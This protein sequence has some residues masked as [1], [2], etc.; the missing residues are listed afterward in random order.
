MG[1]S[2]GD[3][4]KAT[5]QRKLDIASSCLKKIPEDIKMQNIPSWKVF[6]GLED[7]PQGYRSSIG[8]MLTH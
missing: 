2:Q 7:L 8:I 6:S 1:T 4:L 5:K 3:I